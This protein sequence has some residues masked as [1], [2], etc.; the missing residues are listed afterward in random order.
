MPVSLKT[1]PANVPVDTASAG[2]YNNEGMTLPVRALLVVLCG[3][4]FTFAAIASRGADKLEFNRDI[5]PILSDRCFKCHGPDKAA[6]KAG[7]RLDQQEGAYA[8]RK[9]HTYPIVPGKPENSLVVQKIFAKDD[10]QRMPPKDS[11]LSLTLEEKQKIRRWIAE[12]AKYQPYWAFIPLPDSVPVPAVKNKKWARNEIDNFILARLEKDGLKPSPEAEKWRWLRRVTYDL[13]GLPPT[14][15]ELDNFLRDPSKDAYGKV[16]DRL[17]ASKRFGERMAVPWLDAA[18]YADSYGYQSDALCNSWPYRDWVIRAFNQNLPYDKF[19]TE[20]LAGDLIPHPSR[21][22]RLA[23]A[24]NRL[25]RQ[26]GEGGS[27]EEEWRNEY[28]SDRVQTFGTVF[29]GLTIECAR[30]HDHKFDPI[31][32]RDYYSFGAFF[33]SIDEYGLYNDSAHVPTPTL[34]V[35]DAEQQ[36]AMETTTAVLRTKENALSDATNQSEPAFQNWL[37]HSNVSA[38][39]PGLVGHFSFDAFATNNQVANLLNTNQLTAPIHGNKLVAGQSGQALQFTGDDE[40]VLPESA[41]RLDPWD[42]YTLVFWLKIPPTLTNAII[43]HRTQGTDTGFFGTELSLEQGRLFFVVKRFWPGNAI[44]IRSAE[45]IPSGQWVEIGVSYDGCG[46]AEGMKLFVDGEPFQS[47]ILRD[48]LFKSPQNSGGNL[49]FGAR[50]RSAGLKGG[51]LDE[52]RIYNRPLAPVELKQLHDGHAL[53]DA[54]AQKNL[55]DLREYYLAAIA[56]SV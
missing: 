27:I 29:L 32:Q 4:F 53:R 13:T 5:R 2:L 11:N 43:F 48:H 38:E 17:L 21:D 34:L 26:T 39:I 49:S 3:G 31:L 46:K 9:K 42:Q 20:Q 36:K 23:T 24:F 56:G 18:R 16:V 50:F 1:Q 33:N 30:C 51:M 37:Q 6:R 54:I 10:D 47:E 52:L 19:L 15:E 55:P 25:H 14:P 44:A 35:P 7:L 12:G 22:D 45:K 40:L 28:V 41:G 8:E